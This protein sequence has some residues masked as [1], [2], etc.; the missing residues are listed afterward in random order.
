MSW[1]WSYILIISSQWKRVPENKKKYCFDNLKLK[2]KDLQILDYAAGV[3]VAIVIKG[4]WRG[5][6]TERLKYWVS[7]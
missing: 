4:Y 3:V 5:R 2:K 7:D 6:E 1:I